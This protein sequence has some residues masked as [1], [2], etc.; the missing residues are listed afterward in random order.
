MNTIPFCFMVSLSESAPG[1]IAGGDA[2]EKKERGD[3]LVS[4]VGQVRERSGRQRQSVNPFV[5][6][7]T[8]AL[9]QEMKTRH[10]IYSP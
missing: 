5:I 1:E 3:Q 2:S 10:A 8:D 9:S 6:G 7:T 4:D